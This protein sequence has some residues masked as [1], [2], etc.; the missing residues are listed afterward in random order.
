M[1]TQ[2]AQDFN[3]YLP[4]ELD[5]YMDD[6]NISHLTD[7]SLDKA[8]EEAEY[9]L[10]CSKRWINCGDSDHKDRYVGAKKF[11]KKYKN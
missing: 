7:V 9:V 10:R 6:N 11:L 1:T 2:Q 3:T 8:I 4:C 5:A